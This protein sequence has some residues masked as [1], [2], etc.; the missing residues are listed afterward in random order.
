MRCSRLVVAAFLALLGCQPGPAPQVGPGPA[1]RAHDPACDVVF[2]IAVEGGVMTVTAFNPGADAVAFHLPGGC[3]PIGFEGMPDHYDYYEICMAGECPEGMPHRIALA[4]GE[5]T[6]VTQTSLPLDGGVCNPPVPP[7]RYTV[8]PVVTSPDARVCV[9]EVV[10]EQ[11]AAPAPAASTGDPAACTADGDCEVYCPE[12]QGCCGWT[13]GCRNAINRSQ[14]DAFAAAH[15]QS[16]ART[17]DCPAMGCAYE[18]A[19]AA[20]CVNGRCQARDGL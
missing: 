5:R 19:Y 7:G 16:C 17:P 11:V 9:D 15:A 14:R 12:V 13:C 4:P 8:R 3:E 2:E 10:V 1:P 6:M 20:A 18:P